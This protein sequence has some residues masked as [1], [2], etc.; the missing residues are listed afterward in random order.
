VLSPARE[1][2]KTQAQVRRPPLSAVVPDPKDAA[3][4]AGAYIEHRYTQQETA[5]HPGL[6]DLGMG[7]PAKRAA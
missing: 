5:D 6:G 3:G 4:I 2:P 1:I 7:C